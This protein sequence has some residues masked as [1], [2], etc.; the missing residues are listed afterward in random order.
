S[1]IWWACGP[2]IE[3]VF[4]MSGAPHDPHD[5]LDSEVHGDARGGLARPYRVV[6]TCVRAGSLFAAYDV[7]PGCRWRSRGT[8]R[9]PST[10]GT[11]VERPA[12]SGRGD[13]DTRPSESACT[14]TS[15]EAAT[16]LLWCGDRAQLGPRGSRDRHQ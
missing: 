3:A 12:A 14:G 1:S 16:D 6:H 5:E 15:G 9:Q 8:A 11:P 4:P 13:P 7:S 2:I 10:C